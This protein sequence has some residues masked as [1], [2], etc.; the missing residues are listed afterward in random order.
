M[1]D[2][3]QVGAHDLEL[4]ARTE[5]EIDE[6]DSTLP[7]ALRDVLAGDDQILAPIILSAN[8]DMA[9]RVARVEVIDRNPVELR[10]EIFFS[11]HHQAPDH[12]LQVLVL[13]AILRG[14]NEPELVAVA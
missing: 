11:L 9:V 13:G 5:V 8:Q 4:G 6:V 7:Q 14:D 12:R 1:P 10:S 3:P 2:L